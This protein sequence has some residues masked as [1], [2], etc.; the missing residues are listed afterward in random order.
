MSFAGLKTDCPMT[1]FFGVFDGHGGYLISEYLS[2]HLAYNIAKQP[3]F[4]RNIEKA[5][6]SAFVYTDDLVIQRIYRDVSDG[7]R[8]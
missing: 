6:R 1:S 5:V 2:L 3:D 8:R 7:E 4:C